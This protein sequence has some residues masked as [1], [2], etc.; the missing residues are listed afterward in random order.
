MAYSKNL[1]KFLAPNTLT[2]LFDISREIIYLFN[3]EL[4]RNPI[5]SGISSFFLPTKI[6]L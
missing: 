4:V 1:E 3:K 2:A 5:D 6:S